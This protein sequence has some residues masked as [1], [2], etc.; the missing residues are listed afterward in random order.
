MTNEEKAIQIYDV[1]YNQCIEDG[2]PKKVSVTCA[3]MGKMGAEIMAEWKDDK[4]YTILACVQ[5]SF[6]KQQFKG[7]DEFIN[8]IKK[9]WEE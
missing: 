4:F 9:Q 8:D 2:Y 5:Y 6:E 3:I 1:T 7:V